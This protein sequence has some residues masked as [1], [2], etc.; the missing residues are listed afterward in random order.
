MKNPERNIIYRHF[1]ED[2]IKHLRYDKRLTLKQI[3]EVITTTKKIQISDETVRRYLKNLHAKTRNNREL[4]A[5][6]PN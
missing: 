3:A 4:Q 1:L 2:E 5:F 6:L